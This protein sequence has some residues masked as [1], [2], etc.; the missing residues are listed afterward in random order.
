M[1]KIIYDQTVEKW[2]CF[3]VSVQ[4]RTEGNPFRDYTIMGCFESNSETITVHGFY[5]GNGCYKVRFMPSYTESYHFKIWGT[6][7]EQIYTGEFKATEPLG[8]NH[9][10]VRVKDKIKFEYED[11]TPYLSLGTTCY[12]WAFQ[13]EPLR[14]DTLDTLKNAPFNKIRFCVFPKSYLYNLH[15]P[16]SYPYEGTPCDSSHLTEE[17][18]VLFGE[19]A[20]DPSNNWDFSRFH[21]EHF[22]LLEDCI[23][24]LMELGIEAD[25][26]LLHPYD[27]WGFSKMGLENENYYL[28]YV[29][30]RFAAYRN[31]WWSL[32]NE[33][34]LFFGKPLSD[35]E[36]NAGIIC[37]YD[38]YAHLRSIHNCFA[39]Y[40]FHKDWITH[41]SIQRTELYRTAELTDEWLLEYQKPVVL[42]EICYEGNINYAWGNITGEEMTR[43]FWQAVLRGGHPGHGETYLGHNDI[44]WW[45]HG[46][47]LYGDSTE[48]IRFLSDI[49]KEVDGG[50]LNYQKMEWDETVGTAKGCSI[51]YY[52]RFRPSFRDFKLE[53]DKKYVVDV[54]DTW[55]MTV[56]FIGSFQG[57]FRVPLPGREFMAIRIK[58]YE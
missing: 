37:E 57:K 5:D 28:K 27:R 19:G 52:D 43:R 26:I 15:E 53:A 38:P 45:S 32:A 24:K 40:D 11:G 4:G 42:D 14:R 58:E 44:L 36:E 30:S 49:M 46:G 50:V 16:V 2:G 55:N 51:H 12:A 23:K 21:V 56:T 22:A 34:D 31:V 41:C 6:F 18:F 29:V 25:M 20:I 9:G 47:K 7:S 8:N 54:I 48:R 17:N 1:D 33:Y 10:P 13:K 39:F 3:E 35:W